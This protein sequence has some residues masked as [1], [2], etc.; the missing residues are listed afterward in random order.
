MAPRLIK[1]LGA[2]SLSAA[3][4]GSPRASVGHVLSQGGR[5]HDDQHNQSV[6]Q[7]FGHGSINDSAARHV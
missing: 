3:S 6:L 2:I 5:K 7:F 4:D 1:G